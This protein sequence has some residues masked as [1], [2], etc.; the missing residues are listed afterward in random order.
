[1]T[2][3]RGGEGRRL[4]RARCAMGEAVRG[5]FAAIARSSRGSPHAR[6]VSGARDR[7]PE[8]TTATGKRDG[9]RGI[10]PR[11]PSGTEPTGVIRSAA[12]DR[13]QMPIAW[14]RPFDVITPSGLAAGTKHAAC[15]KMTMPP[16]AGMYGTGT[17][18][19]NEDAPAV[20]AYSRSRSWAKSL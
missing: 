5:F 7:S 2:R 17:T 9:H 1:M 16:S 4:E 20:K 6:A 3:A 8:V 10:A 15:V 19:E 14:V 11:W 12:V 13:A 18:F